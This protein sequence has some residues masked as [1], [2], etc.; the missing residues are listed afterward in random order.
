MTS[1]NAKL[2]CG[3]DGIVLKQGVLMCDEKFADETLQL[4]YYLEGHKLVGAFKGIDVILK[5]CGFDSTLKIHTEYPK[6]KCEKGAYWCC[7]PHM[8]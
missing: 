2:V 8:L 4:L 7:C 5:E 3:P 6:F 1:A